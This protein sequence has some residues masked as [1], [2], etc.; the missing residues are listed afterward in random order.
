MWL[1]LLVMAAATS[2]EPVRIGLTLLMLNRPR[3]VLQLMAFLCGG[4]LMGT[5]GGLVVLL[6]LPPTVTEASGLTLPRVQVVIGALAL[7]TAAVLAARVIAARRQ[8][9]RPA[10]SASVPA[11]VS[12]GAQRLL[13]GRSL[14]VAGTAGLGIALPSLDY[15]AAL[16]VIVASGAPTGTQVAALLTFNVVAFALV[17]IPLLAYLVVPD[18]THA[19]MAALNN[20]VRQRRPEQVA[21]LLATVGGVLCTAGILG[22]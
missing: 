22:L 11:R 10:G 13:R 18:A 5:T 1:A 16:A 19:V 2:V 15:L 12:A 14:W 8:G 21:A 7:L 17:E 9:S 4:F 3:P 6:F 20:W